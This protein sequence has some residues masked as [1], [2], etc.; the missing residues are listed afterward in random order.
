MLV[1][2][3]LLFHYAMAALIF[4]GEYYSATSTNADAILL[5]TQTLLFAGVCVLAAVTIAPRPEPP[6]LLFVYGTLKRGM[7]WHSKHLSRARYVCDVATAE[8]Q[9][10][11]L[12]DCGVPLMLR[13][14]DDG[15]TSAG[16]HVRGELFA[17]DAHATVAWRGGP[18]Y[19]SFARSFG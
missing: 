11:V 12:G 1:G 18:A 5:C 9:T 10:L 4:A 19:G 7:H 16:K 3:G 2:G 14:D 13:N 8:P 17:L 15:K 6:S